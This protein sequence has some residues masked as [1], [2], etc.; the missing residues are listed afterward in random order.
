ME[1]TIWKKASSI[2]PQ[3]K[4]HKKKE[5]GWDSNYLRKGVHILEL[6]GIYSSCVQCEA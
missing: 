5:E 1:E 4:E 2:R 6:C 3:E